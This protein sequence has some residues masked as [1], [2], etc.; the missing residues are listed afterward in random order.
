MVALSG[1]TFTDNWE[2][3]SLNDL[4]V[5]IAKTMPRE[6]PGTL[7]SA[8]TLDLVAFLLQFNGFPSGTTALAETPDLAL[9]EKHGLRYVHLPIWYKGI[10]PETLEL[11]RRT[12]ADEVEF[13]LEAG[14]AAALDGDAQHGAVAFGLE[15][16][17]DAAGGPLADGDGSGH[18]M[19][20][21][22]RYQFSW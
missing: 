17:A 7:R 18:G 15:D 12:L 16:F 3:A 13:V 8:E 11:V 14:A 6:A 9:A 19:L 4:F 20:S 1:A 5:K 2:A 10:A 21:G 22:P